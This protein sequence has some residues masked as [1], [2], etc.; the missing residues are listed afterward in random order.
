MAIT[1]ASLRLVEEGKMQREIIKGT[2]QWW[3]YHDFLAGIMLVSVAF[4]TFKATLSLLW[5][6]WNTLVGKSLV[7]FGTLLSLLL[8]LDRIGIE[9]I[10]MSTD[11]HGNLSVAGTAIAMIV[12]GIGIMATSAKRPSKTDGEEVSGQSEVTP[13]NEEENPG[14]TVTVS[15]VKGSAAWLVVHSGSEPGGIIELTDGPKMIGRDTECEI[16]LDDPS[17]SASHAVIQGNLGNY[18]LRDLGSQTGTSINGQAETGVILKVGGKISMGS[19]E[20]L[21]TQVVT[22]GEQPDGTPAANEGILLVKSGRS[23]GQSFPVPQGDL[24]IGRQPEEGGARI[25]DPFVSRRHALLRQ[26]PREARLHDL[27]SINGTKIDD[28][29]LTGVL[30]KNGDTL[31][32]GDVEV[33]FVQEESN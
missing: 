29:E 15:V 18:S 7:M 10:V 22:D 1:H 23:M 25:D 32:F 33:Q 16:Q 8:V 5:M 4:L 17:V 24:V 20:L 9:T 14:A 30:L 31:K 19:S 28:K 26:M 6:S 13:A 2:S 12:G 27:G 11:A 21:Y 3:P